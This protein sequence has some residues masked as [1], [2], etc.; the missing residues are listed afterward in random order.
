MKHTPNNLLVTGGAGFIG[1]N[2]VNY[3]FEQYPDERVVVLDALT[4]AGNMAN[5]SSASSH[6]NFKFVHGDILDTE[7]VEKLLQDD[8]INTI[9]HESHVDRSIHGPDAFLK[10]NIEGTHSLLKAAKKLWIDEGTVEHRFH[11][12]STDEVYGTLAADDPPFTET[13]QYLPNSP[14]AASKASSDHIVRSYHHTFGLNTTISNCSNNY[15]PFQFPE[16]LIPLVIANS[17]E[18]KPLPIYGDGKQIRDWLHVDDHNHG[19]DLIIRDGNVDN[20]YNIGGNNEWANIDIVTLICELMDEHHPDGAPHK[21]LIT[22]VKDRAG[23]DRRYAI[24]ATKIT[25][26]LGYAPNE[27]FETGIKKTIQW[28]LENETWWRSVMDGSY[29]NWIETNYV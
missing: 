14:Y 10:T 12:V 17:L 21:D 24:D 26:E 8:V 3:W 18:G 25:N 5:L 9:V 20:T 15:G 22:H 2:F 19:I 11:H 6:E 1:S 27:T 28:Y 13:N 29:Q 7:L 4:Y 23:H 16:K